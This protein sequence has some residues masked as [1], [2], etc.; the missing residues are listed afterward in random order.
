MTD[1]PPKAE[2]RPT[3]TVRHGVTFVDDYAWLRDEHWQ[4]VLQDPTQLDARVR[5]HLEAENAY[6]EETTRA[7]TPLRERLFENAINARFTVSIFGTIAGLF[8][9]RLTGYLLG[10]DPAGCIAF[11]N[12]L[13]AFSVGMMA[14]AFDSRLWAAPI[15][16][17]AGAIGGALFPEWILYFDGASN[18]LALWVFAFA[19]RESNRGK[20]AGYA[21]S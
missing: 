3:E 20:G 9:V 13:L 15:P 16:F 17:V 18:A 14:T 1:T 7:L 19:W 4:D 8:V 6:Y 21:T 10:L 11:E 2:T 5:A 12:V